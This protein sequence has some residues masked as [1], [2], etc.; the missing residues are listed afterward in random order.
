MNTKYQSKPKI[1][2]TRPA[3]QAQ[4]LSEAIRQAGGEPIL[5]P[6]LT[7]TDP[8]DIT[9]LQQ[10]IKNRDKI[11][12]AIFTSVNAVDKAIPKIE[13]A[14]PKWPTHLKIVAIGTATARALEK[15]QLHVDHCPSQFNSEG[16]L[17]LQCLNQVNNKNIA[18]FQGL[19][20]RDLLATTL[21][22]RGANVTEAI[23][24]Q[25][26]MPV[27]DIMDYLPDWQAD[28]ID[29]II[30]TS[31]ES[32]QN[33]VTMVGPQ[34]KD[35]LYNLPLI[36]I[37]ERMATFAQ[38]IGFKQPPIVADNASDAALLAAFIYWRNKT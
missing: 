9:A 16:I 7:I 36:V 12:I 10:I 11:H 23:A 19:G 20:G 18:I 21:R 29:V 27:V 17:E 13:L 8:P 2:I 1:L 4:V 30:S 34:E 37:S 14:W 26:K 6:T 31:Q 25:R 3:H 22:Q 33:L 32:L 24:Y 38:Q 35:W 15:Y 28:G 5:F